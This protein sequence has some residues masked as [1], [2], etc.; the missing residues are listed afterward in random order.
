MFMQSLRTKAA[1]L[2][3]KGGLTRFKERLN[4]DTVGGTPFLGL[5]KTVIKAHGASGARAIG[6]AIEQARLVAA[7]G[8]AEDIEANIGLMRLER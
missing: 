8:L 1:A 3:V 6:N 5:T 2:L 7:S 4:P